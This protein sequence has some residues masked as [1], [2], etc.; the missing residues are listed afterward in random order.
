MILN[1][2]RL[3][4][5]PWEESDASDLYEYANDP[6]VGLIAGWPSHK[7]VEESLKVIKNVFNGSECYAIC[8]KEN[9]IPIGAIE[10]KLNGHTDMTDKDD[11]CELG[12][13]LGKPFWGRG[14]VPEAAKELIRHG[15]EDLGMSVIWCGYYDGNNK[16]KRVQE[17]VGF[18]Y[19]HTCNDVPVPLLGQVRIGHTNIM[20]REQWIA[21]SRKDKV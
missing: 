18:V 12:Y 19:H 17:K 14:Y 11:E 4:L 2:E 15:F 6:D 7:N 16:S 9:N 13:W 1:T 8:E 10:L 21:A 20:T 3:R 5:R